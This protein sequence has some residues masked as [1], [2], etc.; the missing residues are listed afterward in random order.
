MN[1]YELINKFYYLLIKID[2]EWIYHSIKL[3]IFHKFYDFNN[4]EINEEL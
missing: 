1:L 4:G 2:V 3:K